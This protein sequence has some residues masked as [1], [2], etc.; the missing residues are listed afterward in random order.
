MIIIKIIIAIYSALT[1]LAIGEEMKAGKSSPLLLVYIPFVVA[2]LWVIFSKN[3]NI[4]L[5]A[6]GL[7]GLIAAA[8]FTG[9]KT[10]TFDIKHIAV[11]SMLSIA[12]MVATVMIR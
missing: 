5:L 9:I 12:I 4:N 11:R 2:M 10:D 1:L 8:I 7:F 6:I 3:V